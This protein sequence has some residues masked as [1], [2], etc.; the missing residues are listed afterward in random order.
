[1]TLA[2]LPAHLRLIVPTKS[3]AGAPSPDTRTRAERLFG[4]FERDPLCQVAT[5][6]ALFEHLE[7]VGT[8][9]PS[10]PLS[11][12]VVK[13]NGLAAVNRDEGWRRGDELLQE[14]AGRIRSFTRTTDVVGRLTGSS[15]GLVLQGA[16]PTAAG[17]VASRL[18]FQLH[19]PSI[20]P[21]P[22]GVLVSVA[23]GT[24]INAETLPMAALD[25]LGEC[26]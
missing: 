10:A 11:L 12:V 9:A 16:G 6:R 5:R 2:Q 15:F 13:V 23:T 20:V 1:M 4:A 3:K 7:R 18:A 22:T 8:M 25:S 14:I 26:S 19:R 21:P 17:A 24:G